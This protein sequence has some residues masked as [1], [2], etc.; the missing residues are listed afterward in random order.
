MEPQ[1]PAKAL[2]MGRLGHPSS[3]FSSVVVFLLSFS[4]PV[5]PSTK[6]HLISMWGNAEFKSQ[7]LRCCGHLALDKA[8]KSP[9]IPGRRPLKTLTPRIMILWLLPLSLLSLSTASTLRPSS[10]LWV[11][12]VMLCLDARHTPVAFCSGL[13]YLHSDMAHHP[14]CHLRYEAFSH[15]LAWRQTYPP[16]CCESWGSVIT[17]L[18]HSD[19]ALLR[20]KPTSLFFS[21]RILEISITLFLLSLGAASQKDNDL[22]LSRA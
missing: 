3:Y 18:S 12:Q 10:G 4:I 19:L 22:L 8:Q 11:N 16:L 20:E 21:K 7:K 14:G 9:C 17:P 6:L 13:H 2:T 15:A 5:G 1:H